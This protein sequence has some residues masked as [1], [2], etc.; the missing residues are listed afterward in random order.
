M[1]VASLSGYLYYVIFIDDY[2]RKT[3]IYFL[4]SMESEEFLVRFQEFKARIENLTERKIKTL[5]SNNGGEYTS[6]C[7]TDFY[8]ETRIKRE[9][10]VPYNPQQNGVTERKNMS[11]VEATKAMIHDQSLPMFLWAE[12]SMTAAYVQNR[13]PH[14]ILKNITPEEAFTGVKPEVGHFGIFG[15]LVY[16]HVPKEKRS[17]LE[18]SGRKGTFV[19]YNESS[20]EYRIYISGQ[21]QI[22]V[23]RDVSFEEE[24]AFRKSRRSHIE[25]D[26]EREEEMV[27]SPPHTPAVQRESDEPVETIEPVD[28]VDPTEPVHPID[29]PRQITVGRKRPAWARQTLQEAEGHAGPRGTFRESK[30]PQRFSSYIAAMSHIIDY[31]PSSYEEASSQPI[32]KDA[33]TEEYQSIMKNDVWDIVPRPKG[34]YMVTSKWIYKIKHVADESIEK[35]KARFVARGFSQVEGIDYEET[36]APVARYTSIRTIIALASALGW[37]LHQ[38]DVKTAFLNGEIEEE[39][40]IEKLDGFVI[41]GKESHVCKLNKALYGLKQAPRA[42]YARI[43]GYLMSLSFSKTVVDANL[44][45]KVDNGESL[46]LIMYVDDLFLTGAEHLN[47]WCKHELASEFEIK[48]LGMMHYF[49]RLEVWQRNDEIFLSQGK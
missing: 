14:K 20:K 39:V 18:P 48:D 46:I 42:W 15:C 41:H 36:F 19:G 2:P 1:T 32:W 11:I 25:T 27:S 22:E 34:K 16:I 45:Y 10:I 21:R 4:K 9:D 37:R 23:S 44:Y 40:Y 24:V 6:K 35:H 47:T 8:I 17:K 31:E 5:R 7:F 49:L 30:R 13:N 38:T 43:D 28:P 12:A 3:W 33:M 29:V 26:S